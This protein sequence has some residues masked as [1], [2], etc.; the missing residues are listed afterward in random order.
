[1][2]TTNPK[3]WPGSA[4]WTLMLWC[5][6]FSGWLFPASAH[7]QHIT[8]TPEPTSWPATVVPVKV[9]TGAN[10]RAGP[11]TQYPRIG[12]ARAGQVITVVARNPAGDWYQ[13][14]SGAWIHGNLIESPP[15]VPVATNSPG[16]P[17]AAQSL[18]SDTIRLADADGTALLTVKVTTNANLRAGPG[19]DYPRVGAAKAGETLMV[20][21]QNAK[22]DWYQTAS[23]EWIFRGLV[24][25]VTPVPTASNTPT[26]PA[27]API[28]I[29]TQTPPPK[30]EDYAVLENSE[31]TSTLECTPQTPAVCIREV[32][33]AINQWPIGSVIGRDVSPAS[34]VLW[35]A[36][37]LLLLVRRRWY[38]TVHCVLVTLLLMPLGYFITLATGL[39]VLV[40]PHTDTSPREIV[41]DIVGSTPVQIA[42]W[43]LFLALTA[44]SI[45]GG[46]IVFAILAVCYLLFLKLLPGPGF[47]I[48]FRNP[49]PRLASPKRA[50]DGYPSDGPTYDYSDLSTSDRDPYWDY[51][52]DH[53]I[54]EKDK[55]EDRD[56]DGGSIWDGWLIKWSDW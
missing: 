28:S 6:L 22:G 48:S 40:S 36:A 43:L 21:A 51:Y 1:M 17:V 54:Y 2:S 42:I 26:P 35:G 50:D 12:G 20:V 47:D 3:G 45:L 33:S 10:L 56:D 53:Y 31:R 14:T 7:A 29:E 38:W 15:E 30:S 11:G 13:L 24:A 55:D 39:L 9:K 18:V 37:V 4:Y 19:T 49:A 46:L 41:Q 23:G 16:P 27:P 32:I 34:V 44:V 8:P 25:G 5:S 52:R